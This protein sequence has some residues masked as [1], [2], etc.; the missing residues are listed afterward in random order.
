MICATECLGGIDIGIWIRYQMAFSNPALLPSCQ[1]VKYLAQ[2]PLDLPEQQLL[3]V[4]R[5]KH[6]VVL[7]LP[8][9][10]VKMILLC[11]KVIPRRASV[12]SGR[13]PAIRS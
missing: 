2:M 8:S 9:R 1:I 7:A 13:E 3:A 5:R 12:V 6:D 4:L 10:V 11:S